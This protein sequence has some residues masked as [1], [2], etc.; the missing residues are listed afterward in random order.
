MFEFIYTRNLVTALNDVFDKAYKD[1]TDEEKA[2]SEL[3]SLRQAT[4]Y[5]TEEIE[6]AE[7]EI[8]ELRTKVASHEQ[9]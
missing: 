5:A 6:R 9:A 3:S 2:A 7:K 4:I 1:A 8:N